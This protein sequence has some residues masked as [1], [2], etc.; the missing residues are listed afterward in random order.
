MQ[1]LQIRGHGLGPFAPSSSLKGA[2]SPSR[3][4]RAWNLLRSGPNG[5]R[6]IIHTRRFSGCSSKTTSLATK[7]HRQL[8]SCKDFFTS[9]LKVC[10]FYDTLQKEKKNVILAMLSVV[11]VHFV[12]PPFF[13]TSSKCC[14]CLKGV[15]ANLLIKLNE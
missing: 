6:D 13:L 15:I 11:R 4:A 1:L 3:R 7:I 5:V 9:S 12:L 8:P 14:M 10:F 2:S